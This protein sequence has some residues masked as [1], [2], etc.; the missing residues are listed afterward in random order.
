MHITS[1]PLVNQDDHFWPFSYLLETISALY[2]FKQQVV[3]ACVCYVILTQANLKPV[4]LESLELKN[5]TMNNFIL[6]ITK[7]DVCIYNVSALLTL[8]VQR[9]IDVCNM[10]AIVSC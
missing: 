9:P 2:S 7:Q 6:I 8:A 4:L 3:V 5:L 1:A 10:F